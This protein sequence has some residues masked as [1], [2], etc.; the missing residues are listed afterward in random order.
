MVFRP[1]R[2]GLVQLTESVSIN[3]PQPSPTRPFQYFADKLHHLT[4]EHYDTR[5]SEK[6][7]RLH[8]TLEPYQTQY[9]RIKVQF[10]PPTFESYYLIAQSRVRYETRTSTAWSVK[11]QLY[12]QLVRCI[13]VCTYLVY[14]R[15]LFSLVGRYWMECE[16][17]RPIADDSKLGAVFSEYLFGLRD[18]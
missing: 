16:E 2:N 1:D 3:R 10:V 15:E 8:T 13:I 9:Q 6:T 7:N 14:R 12:S 18:F 5:A 11:F 4:S 17:M